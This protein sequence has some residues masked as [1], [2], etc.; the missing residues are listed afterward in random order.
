MSHQGRSVR[1][2]VNKRDSVANNPIEQDKRL[3]HPVNTLN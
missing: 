1:G 3:D 2:D